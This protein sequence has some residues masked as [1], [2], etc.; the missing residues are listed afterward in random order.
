MIARDLLGLYREAINSPYSFRKRDIFAV[1]GTLL[2][3]FTIPL[4]VLS[5]NFVRDLRSRAVGPDKVVGVAGPSQFVSNELLIKISKNSRS[6]VK[7]GK[8][9]NTGIASLNNINRE[10]KVAKFEKVAKIGKKSKKDAEIFAWYKVS[11][12]GKGGKIVGKLD[13]A[14]GVIETKNPDNPAIEKL[15][16]LIGRFSADPN[17]EVVEPNYIVSILQGEATQSGSPA[18]TSSTTKNTGQEEKTNQTPTQTNTG[19]TT[20]EVTPTA[21]TPNDP[22]YS[23]SGSWGQAYQDLYGIHKINAASAWDQSTGSDNIIVAGVDTGV[24]RNHEDLAGQM[25]T[26]PGETPGNGLDDDGNGYVDDYHGWDFVN[27]DGDPMD[28]HG[29]GTHTVGTIAGV[30]NNGKGVVGVNWTSKIM[31]VKFLNSAGSG[32]LANGATALQYAADM[33]ARVSSNSWGCLCQ[34]QVTEDAVKYQ[35]DLGM[36]VVVAAGNSNAD[37]LDHS[38]ASADYAITVAASDYNDAKASFSN[39]GEKIDVA[40]PGVDILSLKAATSP[41]CTSTRTVGTNYCRVSGTSMATPHV[42]GL[43]ALLMAKNPG[44]TNEAVRQIIRNGTDDIGATGKDKS[45]GYGRINATSSMNLANTQPLTPIITSPRS[46]E[47]ISSGSISVKGA[48]GGSDFASYKVE[49]GK[50]RSPVSWTTIGSSTSQPSAGA[51]LALWNTLIFSDGEYIIRLSAQNSSGKNYQYQV[52]DVIIDNFDESIY[53]PASFVSMG[54]IQVVG[55]ANTKNNIIFSNYKLEWGVGSNPST[56]STS[57]INLSNGGTQPISSGV[58]GTWDTTNLVDNTVYTI[59]LTVTGSNNNTSSTLST[60]TTDSKLVSGWPKPIDFTNGWSI[61]IPAIADLDGDGVKEIIIP[62]VSNKLAVYRKDGSDF[63]GFPVNIPLPSGVNQATHRNPINVDDL[64]G[65]GKKEI[66]VA[67]IHGNGRPYKQEIFIF[68]SDGT[69]YP[70]WPRISF[71]VYNIALSLDRTPTLA[72]L[73]DDGK[74]ELL[75]AADK[76]YAYQLDGSILPN[77]SMPVINTSPW[78][79][80]VVKDLDSDGELEIGWFSGNQA[81]LADSLGRVLPGWP[82][83]VPDYDSGKMILGGAPGTVDLNGDGVFELIGTP[84]RDCNLPTCSPLFV[85]VWNIDGTVVPNY[86]AGPVYGASGHESYLDRH[87]PSSADVDGDG[88]DEI[89]IA[90]SALFIFD[91][92]G[93]SKTYTTGASLPVAISDITGD[94]KP[95]FG[96][97]AS[98]S[99]GL[100]I[101]NNNGSLFFNRNNINTQDAHYWFYRGSTVIGDLDNNGKAEYLITGFPGNSIFGDGWIAK[102]PPQLTFMYEFEINN[103]GIDWPLFMHDAQRTG[104]VSKD[105]TSP[106]PADTVPPSASI[107]SPANGSDVSGSVNITVSASD[108]VGVTKVE[109]LID[110]V[111]VSS[112]SSSPYAFSWN[113]VT[114]ANGVHSIGAKAYDAAG[115]TASTAINVN[116]QNGDVQPPTTPSSLSATAA[117]YNRVNLSWTASTDNVGVTGYWIVRNGVTIAQTSSTTYSDTTVVASTSYSYQVI[118][119]DAAGNN[120][121]LSNTANVTTPAVPDTQAPTAPSGLSANAVSSSQINMS[122]TASSD[123]V[124]VTGYDVYRNGT[125]VTTVSTTGYGDSGLAASTSYSYF[126]KARDAAGN[127]SANSNTATAT[128]QGATQQAIISGQITDASNG[129]PIVGAI[130]NVKVSGTKGKSGL[131]VSASTNSFGVYAVSVPAGTYDVQADAS[132]YSK[133]ERKGLTLTSG[134]STT[135]SF[136]LQ[137][138]GGGGG[139]GKNK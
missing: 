106:P 3:F 119:Y 118:A 1:V 45:F 114:K 23:S 11:L 57:G 133:A 40:A 125:K 132:G 101:L 19:G 121:G 73:N 8:P 59:R 37:A 97:N 127:V 89:V 64:D 88:K 131:L 2:I 65:D 36:V 34:S 104:R 5:I 7:S 122:W 115:N 26:N 32:S 137:P 67:T 110:G 126:V 85:Y 93:L 16:R 27:N 92:T 28:D 21:T 25:W 84:V 71:N 135:V 95:D 107:T 48:I 138:K 56:W 123:N 53:S 129:Q 46:R 136:N 80:P 112:D 12:G 120:S 100:G 47:L 105:Q 75:I 87:S 4:T 91:Q 70:G 108:N 96:T 94:G 86:P 54:S 55:N 22:Y 15:Q 77:F 58:L 9:T 31:A 62:H 90:S 43:A 33:G 24:D 17:I 6:K 72:D 18:T 10:N 124:G 29:H 83:T 78:H 103:S 13:K 69:L 14:K 66:V 134:L 130:V 20:Q 79:S 139:K 39:W 81:F 82:Y 74:K 44:L 102:G 41:M 51:T 109:F 111:V 30:G 49:V 128:T 35:H 63:P 113:S 42:A 68:R 38:P 52:H 116:V 98:A 61:S 76:L 50:G 99:G 117:A 60:V